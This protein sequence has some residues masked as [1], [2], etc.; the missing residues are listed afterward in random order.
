MT[1]D[2]ADIDYSERSKFIASVKKGMPDSIPGK[3]YRYSNAG[4]SML[5]AVV[6]IVS[7][8]SFE[9]Y[10]LKNIF[11]PCKMK[12]TGYPWEKRI[13]SRERIIMHGLKH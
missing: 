9:N 12:N 10:L 8:Q 11:E 4:F 6:E 3:K 1:K 2:G 13:I 5:A 7:G